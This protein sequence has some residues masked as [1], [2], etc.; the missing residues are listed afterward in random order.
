MFPTLI[1]HLCV[2]VTSF[3]L[4]GLAVHAQVRDFNP[5]LV[6]KE[7]ISDGDVQSKAIRKVISQG[8]V[9]L[10]V[11]FLIEALSSKRVAERRAATTALLSFSEYDKES[12][13]SAIPAVLVAL[14]DEDSSV[15][16]TSLDILFKL[17]ADEDKLAV[18]VIEKLGDPSPSVRISAI[19]L[20]GLNPSLPKRKEVASAV[21]NAMRDDYF[22]VR[23]LA[24]MVVQ[25]VE[26]QVLPEAVTGLLLAL[27]D[28]DEGVRVAAGDVLS[29]I[30]PS[31]AKSALPVFLRILNRKCE[32][33]HCFWSMRGIKMLGPAA[34]EAI[35]A[36]LKI[37]LQDGDPRLAAIRTLGCV[38]KGSPEVQTAL[39]NF[40]NSANAVERKAAEQALEELNNG[41]SEKC[42]TP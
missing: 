20:I 30:D 22:F 14:N 3:Y 23:K 8:K 16:S 39:V 6:A 13:K 25:H 4:T 9:A 7:L 19:Y 36:L 15:R 5:E 28:A 18:K 42:R 10:T 38:G 37:A 31:K 29:S 35:P 24:V 11:P 2:F 12:A 1:I 34:Y 32:S 17:E 27:D 21:L 41:P 40:T 33:K 26:E